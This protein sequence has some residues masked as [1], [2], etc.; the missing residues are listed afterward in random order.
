M[1]DNICTVE[2]HAGKTRNKR[3]RSVCVCVCVAHTRARAWAQVQGE[4]GKETHSV[5]FVFCLLLFS[6][7]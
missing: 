5:S 3:R 4:V 7:S 6:S 2:Y 1:S